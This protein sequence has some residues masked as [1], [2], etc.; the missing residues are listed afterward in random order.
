[1]R[2]AQPRLTDVTFLAFDTETTGLQPI[3]HRLVDVGAIR[4]RLDGLQ[5][6]TFQQVINPHIPI[7]PDVQQVHGITDAMVRGKPTVEQIM[8]HFIEFLSEP[9]TLLL[10]HNAP[11]IS[12]F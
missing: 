4:F 2:H 1:M 7:P 6:A 12:V 9:D 11:L 3:V 5:L 8:P 10:A